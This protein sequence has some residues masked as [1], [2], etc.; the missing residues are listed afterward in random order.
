ML[1][2]SPNISPVS[3]MSRNSCF[4]IF[5]V[6]RPLDSI[7]LTRGSWRG[8][9]TT[10]VR[11][12]V[13]SVIFAAFLRRHVIFWKDM[14]HIYPAEAPVELYCY[15][16]QPGSPLVQWKSFPPESSPS[17][18]S[19]SNSSSS[20][21]DDD[22]FPSPLRLPVHS[23]HV[24]K[25]LSTP[26]MT[27]TSVTA[28]LKKG[29]PSSPLVAASNPPPY[30]RSDSYTSFLGVTTSQSPRTPRNTPGRLD[31]HLLDF[32]N[33]AILLWPETAAW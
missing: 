29:L 21:V 32:G 28:D 17:C 16:H 5:S 11:C 19:L 18:S 10:L 13:S 7:L 14:N 1:P 2:Q 25:I 24:R 20:S 9:S 12:R 15:S 23:D 8:H 33:A 31:A 6:L 4:L 30:K 26:N 3:K 27:S 22:D